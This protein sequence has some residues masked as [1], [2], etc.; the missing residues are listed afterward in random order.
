M[1]LRS[2][3]GGT[4]PWQQCHDFE[5]Q[6]RTRRVVS[7]PHRRQTDSAQ[8]ESRNLTNFSCII[9]SYIAECPTSYSTSRMDSGLSPKPRPS[10]PPNPR[11]F[12]RSAEQGGRPPTFPGRRRPA[13]H[14]GLRLG[15]E[16]E[17]RR[18]ADYA[19]GIGRAASSGPAAGCRHHAG[20]PAS[21]RDGPRMGGLPP[22]FINTV[23]WR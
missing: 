9:L 10:P 20:G 6:T 4:G 19:A 8:A 5:T 11:G 21:R 17:C 1:R 14:A 23:R 2:S 7:V 13:P 3:K 15:G 16:P 18:A 12:R 22:S